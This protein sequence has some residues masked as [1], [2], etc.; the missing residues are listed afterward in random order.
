MTT[1]SVKE[2]MEA[3]TEP[4]KATR[5]EWIGLAV[6]ALAC[7]LYV[8]DLTVLHLAVPAISAD[9]QP[10]SAQLLWIIDIY[11]FVVAGSLITMGS[12]GDRIGRRRLLLIGAAAFGVASV[13]AAFSTSAEML[14]ATRALLGLAGATLAPSTLSLIRNMFLDPRQRT[15]A[16]AVWI[17]S[18]SVGAAIGPLLG[19]LVLEFFWWGAAFLLAVPVMGLLL[20]LGPRLLPEYRDPTAG[21]PDLPSAALSLVAVLS[22]I[23]GLKQIA[24]DGLGWLPV[25]SILAGLAIGVAFVRRQRHLADPF[26]D[27]RLFRAPGFSASLA[28]YGLGIFLVFGGFLFLPQFL[29]LVLGLSPLQAGLWTLPWALA[30]VVG[31]QLTP[32]IVRRVRPASLMAAGMV[33]AAGGF[34]VFTRVDE[35]SG[36]P[37]FLI[38]SVLFSLGLAPV[39]TLAIDLIVGVAP[40]E[41]AGAASAIAETAAEFGGA[42]GIAVFGSIGIA[43]YRGAMA[44][45]IPAG[46][47]AD[48]AAAARDTL[49]G[50][51]EIAGQLPARLG[52]PLI[53]AAREAFVQ[54]VHVA[55]SISVIGAIGLAVFVADLLRR[56][57]GSSEAEAQP[58]LEPEEAVPSGAAV[59]RVAEAVAVES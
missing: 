46:V 43:I 34:A 18:F 15:T 35:T 44:G 13:L 25:L 3:T 8:M 36:F 57:R 19:G 33:L 50:A 45:G 41:R 22:V 56:V 40:P 47:P 21:L 4:P 30:F 17:T 38:G 16:I 59:D 5:R 52:A 49:G 29:Q 53:D 7:I 11:G 24:Q 31:S 2:G 14:I 26:I 39:F 10:S 54:G 42:V 6:I 23:F 20:V 9:L 55:A 1:E 48:A 58:D 27:L 37:V 51:V 28:T 32:R 12:L